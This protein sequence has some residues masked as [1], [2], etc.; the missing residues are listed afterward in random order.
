MKIASGPSSDKRFMSALRHKAD[1]KADFAHSARRSGKA[2]SGFLVTMPL[3]SKPMRKGETMKKLAALTLLPAAFF[4]LGAFAA[5]PANFDLK[6]G[7]VTLN[8]G[9]VMPVAGIGT[10]SLSHEECRQSLMTFLKE[11]GRLIDTAYMYGNEE[12]VGQAVRQS[13]V[14]R[15]EIFVI[16]KIYP[17]QFDDAK[18]AADLALQKLDIGYIDLMLLHHPGTND[19]KAYLTLEDYVKEGLIRNL[20]L[21]NYYI[22]ELSDFLPKVNLKPVLVQ[23]EIHPYYQEKE[24]VPFIQAQDIT[25]QSWYPLGGRGYTE[26]LLGN[27]EIVKIAAEAGVSPAQV[28]LRWALQRGIAVIPGTSNPEHI[29]E[30]LSLLTFELTKEQMER[31]AALDRH[32]KHDWY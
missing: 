29:K 23:N 1:L 22:K 4:C 17:S 19:V 25:V 9:D 18:R 28:V 8:S 12:A 26:A 14:P 32:E 5:V 15:E 2:A 10:Y 6:T 31:I 7:V 3:S 16:T 24:V 21:S 13:G 11:G 30:N 20:G 27:D